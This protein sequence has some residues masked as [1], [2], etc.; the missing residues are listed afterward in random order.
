MELIQREEAMDMVTDMD[1]DM[2]MDTDMVTDMVYGYGNKGYSDDGYYTDDELEKPRLIRIK[3]K[4]FSKW[5]K[6]NRN[7]GD[8]PVRTNSF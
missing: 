2:D 7:R 8:N 3:D 5:W 4:I 1:M 6:K